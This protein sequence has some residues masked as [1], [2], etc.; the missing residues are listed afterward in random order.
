MWGP[1]PSGELLRRRPLRRL[2]MPFRERSFTYESYG[3]F[4][5][6]LA[7]AEVVRLRDFG[8]AR[9]G[10]R[11]VAGLRH[12]VDARLDSALVLGRLEAERGLRATY[13]ALHTA[14]YYRNALPALKELQEQGHEIG[15]HND[16]LSVPGDPAETLRRELDRLREAGLDVVGV[17]GHGSR[18]A[19]ERRLFGHQVFADLPARPRFPNS[20][21]EP[22]EPDFPQVTL[23]ELGLAYDAD[24]LDNGRYYADSFYDGRG[25]RWHPEK[26]DAGALE[27]GAK[28]IVLTHPCHWDAGLSAKLRRA[29]NPD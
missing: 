11:A 17:A 25:R 14:P 2:G 24:F 13:F 23:A 19:H 22:G 6:R 9:P 29:L 20:A 3:A 26:L 28:T 1:R 7:G 27:P 4:L 21:I 16:A 8:A 5:D 12:D 15:L 10:E 18:A